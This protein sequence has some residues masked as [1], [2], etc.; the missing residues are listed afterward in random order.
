MPL[1]PPPNLDRLIDDVAAGR[2][3]LIV[4][5]VNEFTAPVLWQFPL[6]V[7]YFVDAKWQLWDSEFLGAPVLPPSQLAEES[8]DAVLVMVLC[9]VG[10]GFREVCKFLDR[11][12]DL[13]YF[14]PIHTPA[15]GLA[16]T[17][18]KLRQLSIRPETESQ[19][20]VLMVEKLHTGGAERQLCHLALGLRRRG[21]DVEVAVLA[22]DSNEARHYLGDFLAE[23]GRFSQVAAADRYDEILAALAP[24]AQALLRCVP[25]FLVPNT[26]RFLA[27]LTANPPGLLICHLDR[28][29][30]IGA[31]AGSIAGIPRILMS[32]RNVNPTHFPHFYDGQVEHFHAL[33]SLVLGLPGIVFAVNAPFGAQSYA[34]W[35]GLKPERVPVVL[36]SVAEEHFRPLPAAAKRVARRLLGLPEQGPVI[37]GVFRLAPEKRPLLF[38]EAAARV[39]RQVPDAHVLLCGDGMLAPDVRHAVEAH[40]LAGRFTIIPMLHNVGVALA[41]A[42]VML[43]VAQ[44]EGTPNALLE[45]QCAGLPVV[46]SRNGGSE[47]ILAQPLQ[48]YAADPDDVESLVS[49]CLTLLGDSR[50]RKRLAQAIRAHIHQTHSIDHLTTDTLKVLMP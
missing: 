24:E 18:S 28:P 30:V 35:L 21:W 13:P 32:G 17:V 5:G 37:I 8:S 14:Q 34:E 41:C 22:S 7:D 49:H 4:W 40:G 27:H 10:A 1:V 39:L 46:C 29:N 36:N 45:A 2:R 16:D 9:G 11:W 50:L 25:Y 20:A 15:I 47:A 43:H 44:F 33:Y 42:D 19:R 48:P 23:G 6:E 26:L 3:R 38:V 12:P 31:V